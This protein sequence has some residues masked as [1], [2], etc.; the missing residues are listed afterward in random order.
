MTERKKSGQESRSVIRAPLQTEVNWSRMKS[1]DSSEDG[2]GVGA[3]VKLRL[4]RAGGRP[5]QSQPGH[6]RQRLTLQA[7]P[8][9]D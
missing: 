9:D 7:R 4:D 3:K 2:L 6:Q 5:G 1:H 8:A